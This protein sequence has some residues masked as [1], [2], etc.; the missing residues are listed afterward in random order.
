[1]KIVNIIGGLGNQMFQ[2]AFAYKLKDLN[3]DEDVLIDTSHF[4]HIFIKKWKTANLHNGY[5]INKV[6]PNANLP[7]A[8]PWKIMKL[9]R[10]VPNYLAS[11]IV[12]KHFPKRK[13]EIIQQPKFYYAYDPSVLSKS[14]DAYYEGLWGAA[15][16][17]SAIRVKLQQVFAHTTPNEQNAALIADME[18]ENSVGIHIRRGDYLLVSSFKGLCELD[19]YKAGINALLSDRQIHSFYVFSND[20]AW[21]QNNIAPLVGN[22]KLTI[23][24]NN[25]GKN[26]C[27]DMFLMTHCKDLIIANSTFSWW[28][29][30]L[31]KRNGRVIA[32]KKWMNRDVEFDI[33]L[34]EWERL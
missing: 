24:T 17:Y 3:P 2:Y 10:Y 15:S 22:N 4:H 20:V 7:V 1:M 32:P 16:Y 9:S 29:A 31:N 19:Y 28:G 30:F 11:R 33:W 27:W 23:V 14:G 12:R 13:N 26:S 8:N 6:F 5:E 25:I 21:C 34:P 18:R